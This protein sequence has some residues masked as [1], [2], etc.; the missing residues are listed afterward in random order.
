MQAPL[1]S[2]KP[3]I[4]EIR[5]SR[6]PRRRKKPTDPAEIARKV[7]EARRDPTKWG[8]NEEAFALPSAAD[9]ELDRASRQNEKRAQR[10]D[11]FARFYR[12]GSLERRGLEA[13]RRLQEDI[14][15]LHRTTG[16]SGTG[17]TTPNDTERDLAMIVAGQRIE[18]VKR[19]TGGHSWAILMAL[20][21]RDLNG[22]DREWWALVQAVTRE[23]HRNAQ[24]ALV[25]AAAMNLADAYD[26]LERRPKRAA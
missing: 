19:Q 24:A 10:F 5:K 21:E 3:F 12:D 22:E 18:T 23:A 4:I 11:I 1:R 6:M 13:V 7:A 20:C 17:I 14:A 26:S 2:P 16:V 8:W 25:R 9:V 15:I